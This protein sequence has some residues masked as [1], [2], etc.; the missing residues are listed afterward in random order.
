MRPVLPI[1]DAT[2]AEVTALTAEILSRGSAVRVRVTGQSMKPLVPSGARI[3]V[4]PVDPEALRSGDIVYFKNA[5]GAVVLHRIVRVDRDAV[6]GKRFR[7]KGDALIAF[8]DP[9]SPEMVLGRAERIER[10]LPGGRWRTVNLD[11]RRWRLAGAIMA[12]LHLV[13]AKVLL[14]IRSSGK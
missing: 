11:T 2:P 3:V 9:V 5:L 14:R 8:D 7:T 1:I 12:R 4:R 13:G 10:P 6:R